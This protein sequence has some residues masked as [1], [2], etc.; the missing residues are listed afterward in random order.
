M[1]IRVIVPD[2]KK[3]SSI[4]LKGSVYRYLRSVLR[5]KRK[6]EIIILDG[7]GLAIKGIINKIESDKL[8]I[9]NIS[10]YYENRES[11]LKL[12][13]LQG[14][15]KGNKMDVVIQKTTELGVTEIYPVIT[16]RSQMRY[17]RKLLH[18]RK[19]AQES[20]KQSKR[21]TVPVIHELKSIKDVFK[22]V[23][24]IKNK[25]IF[26][27][28]LKPFHKE[29]I[30]EDV[31]EICYFIGP[32]GGFS[33]EEVKMAEENGFKILGLGRRILRAET[34]SIVA[35]TLFQYLYGDI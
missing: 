18:W 12:V 28:V 7:K 20:T 27:E 14:V 13:L 24:N 22:E 9:E 33:K 29:A 16:E 10:P 4:V 1:Q 17:T 15:L 34:A 30:A 21:L 8:I 32:E 25:I 2:I 3:N 26:Y 5:V 19:I 35:T 6:D 11:P 23:A 31:K